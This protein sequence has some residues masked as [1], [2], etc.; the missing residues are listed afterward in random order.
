M[1]INTGSAPSADMTLV[2]SPAFLLFLSDYF[3]SMYFAN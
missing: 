1:D 3:E 2:Y